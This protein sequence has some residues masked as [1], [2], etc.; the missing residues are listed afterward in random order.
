M[1]LTILNAQ[2]FPCTESCIG[3]MQVGFLM[4]LARVPVRKLFKNVGYWRRTMVPPAPQQAESANKSDPGKTPKVIQV[5]F[6]G[7]VIEVDPLN[8]KSN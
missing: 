3:S 4:T 6:R 8:H 1:V 2:S 5:S 7:S